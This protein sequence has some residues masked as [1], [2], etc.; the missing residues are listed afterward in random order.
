MSQKWSLQN[1]VHNV[2]IKVI[3]TN[4]G[5]NNCKGIKDFN[6]LSLE[7]RQCNK[8]SV[9]KNKIRDYIRNKIT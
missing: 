6:S 5:V 1:N 7:I 3:R 8:L 9:F 2:H 4:K